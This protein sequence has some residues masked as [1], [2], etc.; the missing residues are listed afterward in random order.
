[1]VTTAM[2]FWKLLSSD[3][4][5]YT[6]AGTGAVA[7]TVQT[8]LRESVSVKDFGAVGDGTTDDTD[9]IQ[10]AIN[11][12]AGRILIPEGNYKITD[13]NGAYGLLIAIANKTIV[14]GRPRII[15]PSLYLICN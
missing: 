5:S 10:A 2:E 7:T 15:K 12:S 6:P 4:V 9:A 8:K 3:L 13:K 1:M 14:G 11:S